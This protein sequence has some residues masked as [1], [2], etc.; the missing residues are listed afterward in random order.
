MVRTAGLPDAHVLAFIR[1]FSTGLLRCGCNR[2]S[3]SAGAVVSQTEQTILDPAGLAF[4]GRLDNALPVYVS[5]RRT[6]SDEPGQRCGDGTLVVADCAERTLDAGVLRPETDQ[7][8][9]VRSFRSLAV[10]RGNDLCAVAGRSDRGTSLH[11]IS[12]LGDHRGRTEPECLAV[13]PG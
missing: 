4:P 11:A 6:C 1:H 9:Y 2:R 10:S 5:R 12:A 8:G 13:E 7:A 3:V